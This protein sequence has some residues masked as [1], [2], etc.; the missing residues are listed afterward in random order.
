MSEFWGGQRAS[1]LLGQRVKLWIGSQNENSLAIL[2]YLQSFGFFWAQESFVS[3]H[4]LENIFKQFKPCLYISGV[5]STRDVR[6]QTSAL[7]GEGG[8]LPW[9]LSALTSIKRSRCWAMSPSILIIRL[10]KQKWSMPGCLGMWAE[11]A[12]DH[13]HPCGCALCRLPFFCRLTGQLSMTRSSQ[14]RE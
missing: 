7:R 6:R 8:N 13:L 1:L 11:A 10:L 2:P 4:N 9:C 5:T 14:L 3:Q 12:L